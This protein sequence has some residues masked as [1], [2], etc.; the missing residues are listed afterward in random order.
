MAK[1]RKTSYGNQSISSLKGAD[2]VRKRPSVIFGS[3]GL[4]GCFHGVFEIISNSTDE[5]KAGF[6]L[7]IETKRYKD[8]SISVRDYGR[9]VPLDYNEAEK[10]YNWDLI[11][12]ELYAGGKYN[13][14][15]NYQFSL[16]LNGLGA[17]ATQYAS[18]YFD[19]IS[20]RD[21]YEYKV[22]FEKGENIGGLIKNPT[23]E[24]QTGTFQK[25]KPDREVFTETEIP[26]EMFQ[27]ALKR[28]AI[29]NAGITYTLDDEET[30]EHFEYFYPEGIL[31][32][33]KELDKDKGFS[34]PVI[35]ESEGEG[36]DRADKSLY[37]VKASVAFCFNNQT[38]LLEYFHNSSWLE[39]GG[40]PDKAVRSAFVSAFDKEIKARNKYT[41][42]ESKIAF[43]DIQ[44]SLILITNSFSTQTSYA[45]QTKKAINNKFI[46]D[47]MTD[48]IK[49]NLAV[50]FIENKIDGDKAIE[51]ILINKRSRESS[52]AQRI[53]VKKKLMGNIDV[54]NR[55][56]K[57]VDCREKDPKKR[58][59]FIVEG[60]QNRP[61]I[62]FPHQRGMQKV[63]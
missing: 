26:I 10:R 39:H 27:N 16:G 11:Y 63:C 29:I 23:K 58:E 4:E 43:S 21:G 32:Y 60:E 24:T 17:C 40:S 45:N 5:A 30:G 15:E 36:K 1:E 34:L 12:C 14:E 28:Q 51:Q 9:G 20:I 2:R 61:N 49:E 25:W 41:K 19:A 33:I 48:M 46:Q 8:G 37:K 3:D 59:L 31:G 7:I 54:T 42:N 52:E 62:P 44:D 53:S 13:S 56:Q 50:W 55:V 18:E 35:F 22:H 57:F 6:G 47:F 38:N